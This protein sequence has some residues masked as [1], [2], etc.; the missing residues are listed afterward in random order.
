MIETERARIIPI[1]RS[2][3]DAI[4]EMY[5]EPDSNKFIAPLRDK[6]QEEYLAFLDSK[7]AYN[8]NEIGFWSV[9]EK[10]TNRFVGTV[11]L[12]FFKMLSFHH[13]GCHLKR[14]FWGQGWATELLNE[15]ISYGLNEKG[16]QE[17][18]GVVQ[19]GND[20]SAHLMKKIG[21]TYRKNVELESDELRIYSIRNK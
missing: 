14:E 2:H 8:Q 13:I 21:L 6:T 9:F 3:F 18:H 5:H 7:I 19:I 15:L 1:D 12:N 10:G 16:M 20:A 11:N 4:I 17:I